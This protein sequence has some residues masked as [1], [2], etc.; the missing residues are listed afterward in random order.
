MNYRKSLVISAAVGFVA[1]GVSA[2]LQAQQSNMTFFITSTG[3][4]KAGDLGG[5]AGADAHC[6]KLAAAAG[7]GGKTWR[8]FLS[9]T[10]VGGAQAV[11]ARDR[12][13]KGPWQNAKGV[14]IAKDVDDLIKNAN[15]NKETGLS[16]KGAPTKGRGD[17]PN[18]H[19]MLTGSQ[20]DGTAYPAGD[21]DQTCGNWTKS[22]D[23]GTGARVAH[24]DRIGIADTPEQKSWSSSHTTPGCSVESL[25][26]V[27]GGG[28][29][30]CFAAN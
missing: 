1:L 23:D 21:K 22:G 25:R 8:A 3:P 24:F 15:I 13:G 11:N 27:G 16:E 28:L 2:G 17:T 14:V 29:F 7:A 30:Y 18:E 26:K 6:Q 10:A 19:D 12:I 9:Q 5:L 4:G 20:M